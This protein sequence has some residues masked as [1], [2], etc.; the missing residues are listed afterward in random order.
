MDKELNLSYN[1]VYDINVISNFLARRDLTFLSKKELIEKYEINKAD[2]IIVLGSSILETLEIGGTAFKND[3]ATE[4]MIVGGIGHSTELLR[5]KIA[6]HPI[7]WDINIKDRTEADILKDI[8][9][10]HF[11]LR[12]EDILIENT[13]TNCGSNAIEALKLLKT[14]GS[15]PRSIILIQ[16]PTMQL[17]TYASFLKAW[18][19]EKSTLFINFSPIL[20]EIELIHGRLIHNLS[21]T[22]QRFLSLIMGE[23]P[24]LRDDDK[25]YGPK[26][27][28][29]IVHVDIPIEVE[30][31]YGRLNSY[32]NEFIR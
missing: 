27:K 28:S 2:L 12:E 25:G 17:R 9:I 7:Y 20:P 11:A 4:I 16:D 24:R 1:N 18:E 14:K 19:A 6:E 29:Y 15:S 5:K 21:W 32:L 31:A 3:L 23:I 22:L 30:L 8:L 13:S 10:K 26:G